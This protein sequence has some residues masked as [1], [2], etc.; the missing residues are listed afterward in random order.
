MD[1]NPSIDPEQDS[2]ESI[3]KNKQFL[4]IFIVA[5][6]VY[7][8]STM[9]N[10]TLPKYAN[11]LGATAQAVGL[12]AGIFQ[13][14]ALMMRPISGQIVDN[15]NRL[16]MLRA[17][18]S[19]VLLSVVGIMFSRTYWPL[20]AFRALHG[21]AWGIGST[22]FM[23][24]ASSCFTNKNMTA[25]IGIYGLGQVF[26][27]T[28]APMFA[29][30]VALK[31]GYSTLYI[32]NVIL[33][34]LCLGITLFMRVESPVKKKRNY[35]YNLKN[36]I[37]RPALLPATLTAVNAIAKSSIRAFLIIF[38]G[39]MDI[40]NIGIFFTIQAATIAVTRPVISKMADKYGSAKMLLPSQ[41]STIACLL[42]VSFSHSMV[43]FI[44]AAVIGG[45]GI[46]GEQPILMAECVKSAPADKR[47]NAS[48]TS[49]VGVDV[50]GFIGS[51]LAGLAVAMFGYRN[52]FR[53]FSLPVIAMSVIYFILVFSKMKK[54]GNESTVKAAAG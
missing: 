48:N 19:I 18:L 37:Y 25:G 32:G 26:A 9:L 3:L 7:T 31:L 12:L 5:F 8:S 30:P 20:V 41:L 15:E 49:Y 38:A 43:G 46:S 16:L 23:T 35:S 13:I 34:T 33:I 29:V 17:V 6:L 4:L 47:G 1:K 40:V 53:S 11:D 24:I 22:L 39:T 14:A 2:R 54:Q 27:Q 36:M 28:L 50:G 51:N 42:I 44:I 45:I 10:L 21:L 52:M